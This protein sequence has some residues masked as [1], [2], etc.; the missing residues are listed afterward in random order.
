MPFTAKRPS[1]RTPSRSGADRLAYGLL[2]SDHLTG[3]GERGRARGDVYAIAEQ[4]AGIFDDGA[5][6]T[7]HPYGQ[8]RLIESLLPRNPLLHDARGVQRRVGRVEQAHQLVADSLDHPAGGF[9]H[10]QPQHLEAAH[11]PPGRPLVSQ[12]FV[13]LGAAAD[14]DEED[15]AGFVGRRHQDVQASPSARVVRA[16]TRAKRS[17]SRER[18]PMARKRRPPLGEVYTTALSSD[19]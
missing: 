7:A 9:F 6:V 13:Q 3:L 10:V 1:G 19:L 15:G 4:V 2:R 5:E 8:R 11:H 16:R 12:R 14:I 18:D 17:V